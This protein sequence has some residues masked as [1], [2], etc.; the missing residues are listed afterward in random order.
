MS[1]LEE[2]LPILYRDMHAAGAF[3]GDT[4][5]RH[6]VDIQS[7]ASG[8]GPILDYG[9]GPKGG[10]S[11][12]SGPPTELAVVPYD[13]YVKQYSE[14]PWGKNP[15]VFFSCDVFEHMTL[16]DLRT[17]MRRI[18]KQKSI[19]KV[20]ISL[21]TRAANKTMPNGMNA[22]LTVQSADWWAGFFAYTFEEHFNCIVSQIDR[23]HDDCRFMFIRKQ[24][25]PK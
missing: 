6:M 14:D 8:M 21:S 7:F 17:L 5:R 24:E 9:C 2:I 16:P 18:W 22:H 12:K 25:E 11:D 20:Y 3:L 1:K 15:A 4:W 19:R 23:L 13:P 10:L